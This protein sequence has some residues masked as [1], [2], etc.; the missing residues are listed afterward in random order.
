MLNQIHRRNFL[1]TV[2]AAGGGAALASSTAAATQSDET[3]ET[4]G[5][6]QGSSESDLG[7]GEQPNI[8]VFMADDMGYGDIG[9]FGHPFIHT[10]NLDRMAAEGAKFTNYTCDAPVCT[11]TR[12][13]LLTGSYPKR[14]GM[15]QNPYGI[16]SVVFPHEDWGLDPAEETI[17]D[18]LSEQGYATGCF[19]KWHLGHRPDFLPTNQGFDSYLGIPYS[20]DMLPGHPIEG[21]SDEIDYPPL[22]LIE[23]D[24]VIEE[25][26]DQ[27]TLT[28][29]LTE[30]AKEFITENQ[31]DSFF[32]YVPYP[33]PHLPIYAS[34]KF[35]GTSKRGLFGD[36]I[37][38]IDWGVGQILDHLEELGLDEDTLVVFTTD[39]GPWIDAPESI[40]R[41]DPPSKNVGSSGP[42]RAGKQ[43]TY[44]GGL[45]MPC[46]MRWPGEIPEN[47]VCQELTSVM[48][49][50]PTFANLAG[51]SETTD[52]KID[53]EDIR[54]LM[55]NPI[56]GSSPHRILLHFE[57]AGPESGKMSVVRHE[58][59]WKYLFPI[60]GDED[61]GQTRG[62]ELYNVQIDISE[63]NNVLD[64][65]ED[66]A[67]MLRQTGEK[68]DKRI[69]RTAESPAFSDEE[70]EVGA[71]IVELEF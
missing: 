16:G 23:D 61:D 20:N 55:E 15:H 5:E 25:G 63:Q 41:A 39:D 70:G 59:G 11:P 50:F 12:A 47:T 53:G 26:V 71:P 33:M 66:M 4:A 44:E 57:G 52:R 68:K 36:V 14:T 9:A 2:G 22:Q 8:V 21:V 43:Y 46:I 37:Q 64:E 40:G 3:S 29:R 13:A 31:D 49:F 18:V 1:R 30:A 32:T 45:R 27:E 7:D 6:K 48:D 42:F 56:D 17:A 69:E 35:E 28:R 19:G 67:T 10:P 24:E 58:T 60:E 54:S 51:A 34:D 38:E 65:N 62:E